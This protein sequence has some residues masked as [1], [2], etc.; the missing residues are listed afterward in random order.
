MKCRDVERALR[1]LGFTK[2]K[3][4][5]GTSHSQ[6]RKSSDRRLFKVTVDCHGGEVKAKDV[7][8]IIS[9]AGISKAA[10]YQAA[11]LS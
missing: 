9:Q 10:F 3:K 1:A 8:S 11:G 6:W 5:K 4:G 7:K 2:D